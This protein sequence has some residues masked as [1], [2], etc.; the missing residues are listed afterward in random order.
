[1][2][3]LPFLRAADDPSRLKR[4][5]RRCRRH[6]WQ[7]DLSG[8]RVFWACARCG[9]LRNAAATRRGRRNRARGNE[10]ER[11]VAHRLGLRRVGQYGGPDDVRGEMWAVQVKSG[12]A[13]PERLWGW[14]AAVPAD[15][16]QVALVVVGDAPGSGRDR[17]ELVI[18][19]LRDW[20]DLHGSAGE[21]E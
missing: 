11:D 1:M 3:E 2:S 18:L 21:Q 7:P 8:L 6:D 17:R 4:S 12:G 15:A 20:L 13:F 14:L 16:S 5:P 9:K 10:Y 19:R